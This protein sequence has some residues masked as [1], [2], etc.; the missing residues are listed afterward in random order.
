MDNALRV[1]LLGAGSAL[2]F[3]AG[4]ANLVA[5]P[6]FDTLDGWS[7]LDG[8]GTA[9][10]DMSAGSPAA[11]SLHV[12]TGTTPNMTVQSSCIAVDDSDNVD[13][14]MNLNGASGSASVA[15]NAYSDAAC[16]TGLSALSSDSFPATNSWITYSTSDVT[17]PD[18]TQSVKIVLV[19]T[20]TAS[21]GQG[22]ASFDHILF[23]PTGT[24][25]G[26][27]DVNQEGLS[28][29]WYNPATSGQG[30]QFQ[31]TP[32]DSNPGEGALFGAWY[33]YDIAAGAET[34]Q[35]WYSIQ[36][37]I[38]GTA[39]SIAVTI[40]QNTGGNF[41]APPGTSAVAVGTGTLSF[42]T[43]TSGSFSYAFDDGRTGTI[44]LQRLLPNVNC[45]ES[46][47][48]ANPVSDF[49]FSGA[50]Y[51]AATSGQGVVMEINPN[52]AQVFIG[53]YSY[54]VS[55]ESAG[56]AGQRWFSAQSPYTVGSRTIELNVYAST[57]GIF[58][59]TGGVTTTPVGTATLTLTSCTT[60]TLDYTFTAGELN[61]QSGSIPLTRLG[62]TPAS[63]NFTNS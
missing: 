56:A 28:G 37:A 62:A 40:Y 2:A 14:Y 11:P 3:S 38:S 54:A 46:G 61:G 60:A 59:G 63:C 33:T 22:E 43:C 41:D 36:S 29:T 18:G 45:V 42:D 55:G 13:L 50:W 39:Q 17:L 44:P 8:D 53:W 30:M 10:L 1:L 52:D 48:P 21:G 57:G 6:D 19:T 34:S 35:R 47:T 12:V 31:F 51:N 25:I 16:T 49:G 58:D 27:I 24:V 15:I 7:V 4:A 5:N 32:D 23:G 26:T 9:T 20:K